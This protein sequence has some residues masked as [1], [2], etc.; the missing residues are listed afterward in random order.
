M[1]KLVCIIMPFNLM[2][3]VAGGFRSRVP[4]N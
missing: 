3:Q 1:E 2:L 4:G